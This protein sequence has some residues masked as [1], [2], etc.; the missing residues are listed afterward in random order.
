MTKFEIGGLAIAV[1]L[2]V[3]GLAMSIGA[4]FVKPTPAVEKTV[5]VAPVEALVEPDP[6]AKFAEEQKQ[7]A[8][9]KQQVETL[10]NVYLHGKKACYDSK[11]GAFLLWFS[12]E[13]EDDRGWWVVSNITFV[14]LSNDTLAVLDRGLIK[15]TS[16]NPLTTKGLDCHEQ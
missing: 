11:L 6:M 16:I 12:D 9:L 8:L 7:R 13:A 1:L 3:L 4:A 5:I 10:S 14:E 15:F 2:C